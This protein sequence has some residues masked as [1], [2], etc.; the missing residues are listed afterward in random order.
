MIWP[1]FLLAVI[2][3]L[4]L[5]LL[6]YWQMVIA[7]G[8]YLGR[9]VVAKSYDWFARRYDGVKRFDP[10]AERW[11]V[12]GPLMQGLWRVKEPLVLDV[13]TGTGRLPLAL[14]GEGFAGQIIGLD[15]SLGMLRQ[16]RDKLAPYSDHVY[17]VWQDASRLPFDDGVFDAVTC[18]EA[19]EFLPR[20]LSA[21][22][23]MVRVLAPDGILFLTNRVGPEA[24]FLPGRAIP[25]PCFE[26]I[27]AE[28][29]LRDVPVRR[30][31]VDYDLALA[32]K[33]GQPA[34]PTM[35]SSTSKDSALDSLLHCPKCGG[36]QRWNA[37]SPVCTPCKSAYPARDGIVQLAASRRKN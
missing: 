21:L 2:V 29:P 13:A 12:A 26:E 18:L 6:A 30:W 4:V 11:Y 31:Q 14:F 22:A 24:R 37:D 17:L 27:L 9:W 1:W 5:A 20:P 7:E 33:L 36:E 16:A 34:G 3:L 19:L 10:R 35:A 23:E 15:L 32:R 25:R 28:L 8:A